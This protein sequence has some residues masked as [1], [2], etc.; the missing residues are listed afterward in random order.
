MIPSL[1]APFPAAA[2]LLGTLAALAAILVGWAIRA[3]RIGKLAGAALILALLL[4]ALAA[5]GLRA[6]APAPNSQDIRVLIDDSPS[7]RTAQYHDP[8]YLKQR[9]ADLL[10]T[11][12]YQLDHFGAEARQTELP[13]L[14]RRPTLL[15]TD[16][17]F[18]LP[19]SDGTVYPVIDPA[20]ERAADAKITEVREE[21]AGAVV[22]VEN[23]GPTRTLANVQIGPG[24]WRVPL[25]AIGHPQRIAL[26]PGDAWP[27]ND[28]LTALPPEREM[29]IRWL[30]A[31]D[32]AAA[33]PFAG[34]YSRTAA[35]IL[36]SS[37]AQLLSSNQQSAIVTYIRELGGT[38]LLIGDEHFTSLRRTPLEAISPLAVDPAGETAEWV[39]LIDASGSMAQDVG[40]V[41]RWQEVIATART[42]VAQLPGNDVARIGSFGAQFRWWGVGPAKSMPIAPP[43]GLEPRGPTDLPAALGE[44]ARLPAATR[45]QIILLTDGEI[46]LPDPQSLLRGLGGAPVNCVLL[47]DGS[48]QSA[49]QRLCTTSGGRLLRAADG[50]WS[51][52]A[53]EL[54]TRLTPDRWQSSSATVQTKPP[55]PPGN[56]SVNG[57]N[58]AFARPETT[59]IAHSG[60]NAM[61]ATWRVGLGQVLTTAF[62]P[63]QS[64]ASV[65]AEQIAARP[66]AATAEVDWQQ[67]TLAIKP[68]AAGAH[69]AVR[70]VT[71][72][73]TTELPLASAGP[74]TLKAQL[75]N[76]DH[77]AVVLVLVDGRVVER[78][79]LPGS[80]APEFR[81]IGLN[82]A[83]LEEL[84]RRTGGRVIEATDR[85]PLA[86][87]AEPRLL[88]LERYLGGLGL[89]AAAIALAS[90]RRRVAAT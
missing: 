32:A 81:R 79:T 27:E 63:G 55:F 23:S 46:D 56:V 58:L 42:V 71:D 36:P 28:A 37:A 41:H 13:P 53:S 12:A 10:G 74:G 5:G 49:L 40:A 77:G 90:L 57:W 85:A 83:N 84:A 75:P 66:I 51:Q 68:Q 17:Q 3:G 38:L 72:G 22:I 87:A 64:S 43:S 33:P 88:D 1:E 9:L 35:L 45:R 16:G 39:I 20:L 80:Y 47:S 11:Q 15:F 21:L 54:T 19:A 30:H 18:P 48:G 62:D 2:L 44:V 24:Q 67:D 78:K 6:I 14:D 29:A 34:E 69:V 26:N 61:A 73:V 50:K 60:P 7:A 65:L 31:N 86:I 89:L 25:G 4:W 59:L 82:R 70:I 76:I 8:A 52:T